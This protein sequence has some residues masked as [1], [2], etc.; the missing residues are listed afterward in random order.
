MSVSRETSIIGPTVQHAISD[1]S[2]YGFYQIERIHF[3][4]AV[5]AV[6]Y[7]FSTV[8]PYGSYYKIRKSFSHSKPNHLQYI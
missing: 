1:C 7:F 6:R 5:E 3:W 2:L 4:M 8:Y